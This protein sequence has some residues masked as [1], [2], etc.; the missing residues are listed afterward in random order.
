M[1]NSIIMITA[2]ICLIFGGIA[3]YSYLQIDPLQARVIAISS[4]KVKLQDQINALQSQVDAKTT[5]VQSLN[6]QISKIQ[7][8]L[9]SL[10]NQLAQ[11]DELIKKLTTPSLPSFSPQP[12]VYDYWQNL[13]ILCPIEGAQIYYTTDGSEPSISSLK[14]TNPIPIRTNCTVKAIALNTDSISSG[15]SSGIFTINYGKVALGEIGGLDY[16]YW[17]FGKQSFNS[18]TLNIT[19]H[20]EPD[21]G[22]GLYFQMYQGTI[23]NEGFYFGLQTQLYKPGYGSVGRGF[24]FS[25][26]GTR[27]LADVSPID[28]GWSESA[29]YEGDFVGIRAPYQWTSHSY[30][31]KLSYIESDSV[32]D[33]YGVWIRDLNLNKQDYMG[34]VRF[35]STTSNSGIANGGIT[36]TELYWKNVQETPIPKWHISIDCIYASDLKIQPI[37]ATSAYSKIA[38]TDI[39]YDKN[40]VIHFLMGYD[41]QRVHTEGVLFSYP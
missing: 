26:W 4:E 38:N 36:W 2:V 16:V 14:Y 21:N 10:N 30:E 28:S 24:I 27:D 40:G 19:I 25:R 5:E 1:K 35:P 31:L 17:D 34:S 7:T 8:Q 23:N 39:S 20:N 12:G 32:G 29:G 33:W 13:T 6:T 9:E 3:I 15:V 11:K 22:D 37:K 41:V 18:L